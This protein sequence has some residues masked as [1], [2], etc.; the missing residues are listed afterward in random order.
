MEPLRITATLWGRL[1]LPREGYVHLDGMLAW[2]RCAIECRPPVLDAEQIADVEIPIQRSAC[3][4]YHLCSASVSTRRQREKRH[5]QKRFPVEWWQHLGGKGAERIQIS[6]GPSKGFRFPVEAT[7]LDDDA[8]VWWCV[9]EREEIARLLAVVTH[10]GRRRAVGEGEVRTWTVE[11]CEPWGPGFPVLGPE[12][13][14]MRHLPL[15]VEGVG[16]HVPRI[17]VVSYPYWLHAREEGIAAPV[18]RFGC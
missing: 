13:E 9:G 12:G 3:G 16:A 11:P 6:A 2:T 4:R 1:I 7:F 10:V 15:D 18:P 17:G 8:L 5:I 14:A